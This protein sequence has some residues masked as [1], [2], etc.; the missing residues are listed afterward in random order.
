MTTYDRF[1][2]KGEEKG[3]EKGIALERQSAAEEKKETVKKLIKNFSKMT[4]KEIFNISGI[5]L[6]L[7]EEVMSSK[8]D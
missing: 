2:K 8:K 4:A 3:I 7:I 5:D 1:V 6:K